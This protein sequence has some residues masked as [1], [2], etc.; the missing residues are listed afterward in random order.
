MSSICIKF[1]PITIIGNN[2]G[3]RYGNQLANGVAKNNP[4]ILNTLSNGVMNVGMIQDPNFSI[5]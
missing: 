5:L 4:S 2:I 3:I 1:K